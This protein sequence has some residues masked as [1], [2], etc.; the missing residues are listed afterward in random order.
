MHLV[1][2]VGAALLWDVMVMAHS[3][4]P[5]RAQYLQGELTPAYVDRYIS[6]HH[7]KIK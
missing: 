6:V 4:W 2:N 3:G 5:E 7:H 1:I